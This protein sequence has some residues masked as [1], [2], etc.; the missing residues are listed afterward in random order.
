MSIVT[1]SL[2]FEPLLVLI[3]SFIDAVTVDEGQ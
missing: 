2:V 3:N 1:V